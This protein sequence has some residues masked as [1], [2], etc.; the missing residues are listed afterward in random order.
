MKKI[1]LWIVI[2]AAV[3][4][5]GRNV[6]AKMAVEQGTRA[7]TGLPLSLGKLD[8]N[9]DKTF[10]EIFNLKLSNPP[11]FEDDVML[12]MPEILV[13]YD[14]PAIF[15]GKVHLEELTV[16]LD[17]FVVIKNSKGELNLDSLKAVQQSKKAETGKTEPTKKGGAAPQVGIDKLSLKVGKVIFKDYSKG[18]APVVK[19]FKIN[20]NE[21][22]DNITNLNAVVSL[23][24]VKALSKTTVAALAN[25]DVNDLQGSLSNVTDASKQLA[26]GLSGKAGEKSPEAK[27][28]VEEATAAIGSAAKNLK[29]KLF[30][31]S[32]N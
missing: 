24:V 5:F 22:Y 17:Q 31:G 3:L 6:I 26:S 16:N 14:L 20:L 19:E 18:G 21:H 30:G 2:I 27:E 32:G 29:N 11:G 8:L 9:F 12:S 23:I 7:V 10:V 28:A 4:F 13:D 15:K 1:F 25:F